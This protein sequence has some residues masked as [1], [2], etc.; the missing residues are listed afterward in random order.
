MIYIFEDFHNLKN[1][2]LSETERFLS[3]QRLEKVRRYAN[4]S[5]RING[6]IAYLLLREG[7][8]R[9]YGIEEK[10]VFYFGEQEKPYLENIDGIYF[11]LSHCN[12]GVA[13]I[14]SESN[15]S[16]DI[17]DIRKV[18]SKTIKRTCSIEE[19][20]ALSQSEYPQR[21][22]IRLWTKK[23][24]YA[25]LDGRGL[26]LNFTE[27][28]EHI[29]EMRDIHTVDFGK[30]ILSYYSKGTERIEKVDA[31]SLLYFE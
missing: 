21:E 8:R 19:R 25:K 20:T 7:L 9:E 24:C 12:T 10:P 15:T 6:C 23:E 27:I 26:S 22:F 17:M 11:S 28:T 3:G 13:C 2:F 1:D 18:Y 30:Y 5:D 29:P 31:E 14:L 4:I 16:A